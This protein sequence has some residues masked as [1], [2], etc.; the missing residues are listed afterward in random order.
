MLK[1]SEYLG[2]TL[3]TNHLLVFGLPVGLASFVLPYKFSCPFDQLEGP[4]DVVLLLNG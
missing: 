4:R 1:K 3:D 2:V